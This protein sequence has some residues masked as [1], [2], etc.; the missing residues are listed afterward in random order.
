MKGE[1][2]YGRG[3]RTK[4]DPNIS[5]SISEDECS[6]ASLSRHKD[7]VYCCNKYIGSTAVNRALYYM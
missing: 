4:K 3:K 2:D 6:L 1:V 7:K 5:D